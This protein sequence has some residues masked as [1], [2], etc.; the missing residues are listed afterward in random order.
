[1][2]GP[3]VE[4]LAEMGLPTGEKKTRLDR[5]PG[6]S[7]FFFASDERYCPLCGYDHV[8][9]RFVNLASPELLSAM[10]SVVK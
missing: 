6:C 10:K 7:E 4:S 2:T 9:A 1:M 8:L 5:C 3:S